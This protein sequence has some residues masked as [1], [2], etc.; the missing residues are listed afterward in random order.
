MRYIHVILAIVL[1]YFSSIATFAQTKKISN[2]SHDSKGVTFNWNTSDN[3][4]LSVD[5]EKIQRAYDSTKFQVDTLEQEK[6]DSILGVKSRSG[7]TIF[8]IDQRVDEEVKECTEKKTINTKRNRKEKK[9]KRKFKKEA[10]GEK[11]TNSS[12]TVAPQLKKELNHSDVVSTD[13]KQQFSGYLMFLLLL[14]I[15]YLIFKKA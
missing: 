6:L 3:L 13:E 2:A 11:T 12:K 1:S 14:P 15:G 10:K 8:L 9:S 7:D 5:Y 4:G